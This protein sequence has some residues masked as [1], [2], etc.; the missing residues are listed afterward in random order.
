[1]AGK[2]NKD[3]LAKPRGAYKKFR[4]MIIDVDGQGANTQTLLQG[5]IR[6]NQMGRHATQKYFQVVKGWDMGASNLIVSK[7][8]DNT[9]DIAVQK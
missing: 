7:P 3:S 6:M 5:P 9:Y 8:E 4:N 2:P 1:M